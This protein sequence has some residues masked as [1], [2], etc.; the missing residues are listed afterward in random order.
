MIARPGQIGAATMASRSPLAPDRGRTAAQEARS[1]GVE[2]RDARVP[3]EPVSAVADLEPLLVEPLP[4]MSIVG[5]VGRDR[6]V[7]KRTG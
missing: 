1:T 3:H 2:D 7:V 5:T 6:P 4:A